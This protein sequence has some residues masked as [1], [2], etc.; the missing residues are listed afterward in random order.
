LDNSNWKTPVLIY[1]SASGAYAGINLKGSK[2]STDG[3]TMRDL[4]GPNATL[5][6]IFGGQV[7]PSGSAQSFL[8]AL[9]EITAKQ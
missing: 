8:A 7:P 1:S 5:Q 4:Y 2:I 6:T 3:Q 9:T